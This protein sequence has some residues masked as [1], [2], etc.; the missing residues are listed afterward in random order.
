MTVFLTTKRNL[1]N[2]SDNELSLMI[3]ECELVIRQ[4]RADFEEYELLHTAQRE[5][6]RRRH[7]PTTAKF[8]VPQSRLIEAGAY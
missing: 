1:R 6:E 7:Q 2:L 4:Q 3:R 8:P 5:L